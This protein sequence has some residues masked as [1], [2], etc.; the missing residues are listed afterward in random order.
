MVGGEQQQTRRQQRCGNGAAELLSF[1]HRYRMVRDP[2]ASRAQKS[3]YCK[4]TEV[5]RVAG[6]PK[7]RPRTTGQPVDDVHRYLTEEHGEREPRRVFE[8]V[9]SGFTS[10]RFL[11]HRAKTSSHPPKRQA[12]SKSS[13]YP[14]GL[15]ACQQE[16]M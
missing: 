5:L 2:N 16:Q 4:H 11:Y 7:S 8:R 9:C 12:Q 13:E 6:L 14:V 15:L 1:V 10:A 3:Q